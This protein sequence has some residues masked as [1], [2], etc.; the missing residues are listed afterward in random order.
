[1][2]WRRKVM[3]ED[4]VTGKHSGPAF[5]L[6]VSTSPSPSSRCSAAPRPP[7]S[8]PATWA[9]PWWWSCPCTPPPTPPRT[10]SGWSCTWSWSSAAASASKASSA[11]SL[12]FSS[13]LGVSPNTSLVQVQN[14]LHTTWFACP[15]AGQRSSPCCRRRSPTGRSKV[16]STGAQRRRLLTAPAQLQWR[17]PGDCCVGCHQS[18]PLWDLRPAASSWMLRWP[19]VLVDNHGHNKAGTWLLVQVVRKTSIY[20]PGL[21][22]NILSF[23]SLWFDQ[24]NIITKNIKEPKFE[25]KMPFSYWNCWKH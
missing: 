17:E 10:C 12:L 24:Q 8:P 9:A 23:F 5:R 3:V 22:V 18:S 15:Q 7:C 2:W 13:T 21:P 1:M 19:Q 16:A 4:L 6:E 11:S 14:L 20:L 25:T